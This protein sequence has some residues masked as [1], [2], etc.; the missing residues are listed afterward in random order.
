MQSSCL[1]LGWYYTDRETGRQYTDY[2]TYTKEN[3]QCINPC[4][5]SED[6]PAPIPWSTAN[7]QLCAAMDLSN[8][9]P[10]DESVAYLIVSE[11]LDI[12]ADGRELSIRANLSPMLSHYGPGIYTVT[13]WATTPDSEPNPVAQYPIWRHSEPTPGHPY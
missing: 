12:S 3:N 9:T 11:R 13:I 4:E 8:S 10:G 7:G 1:D 5:L 6:R 2:T